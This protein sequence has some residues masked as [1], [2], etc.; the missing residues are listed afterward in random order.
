MVNPILSTSH[1][2]L[3]SGRALDVW[4]RTM[5]KY[6]IVVLHAELSQEAV[7]E[8]VQLLML[9]HEQ[10]ALADHMVQS[11]SVVAKLYKAQ[12]GL[13]LCHASLGSGKSAGMALILSSRTNDVCGCSETHAS[14]VR[15]ECTA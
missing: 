11:R 12:V 2:Q 6:G 5:A 1:A 10:M 15:S 8:A 3:C 7:W 9:R 13:K 14:A 4:P